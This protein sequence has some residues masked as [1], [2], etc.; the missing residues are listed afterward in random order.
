MENNNIDFKRVNKLVV[1][2]K[3]KKPLTD[4]SMTM[5]LTI[6]IINRNN[7]FKYEIGSNCIVNGI[8]SK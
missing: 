6:K 2:I 5:P 3:K 1:D 8:L 7:K 4:L